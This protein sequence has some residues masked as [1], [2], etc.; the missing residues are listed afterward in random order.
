MSYWDGTRWI[1]DKTAPT[2]PRPS[3]AANWAATAVM[4]IG[5][6]AVIAPLQF[7]AASSHHATTSGCAVNPS[8]TDV[9]ETYVVSAWGL[10]T[11]TAIN[12]WVTENGVTTGEPIGGTTDGTFTLNR[13]S[14]T[15]GVTTYTFSGP[16]GNNMK[17]YGSCTVSAY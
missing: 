10:S 15:A 3:R 2:A 14:Q 5:L 17:I 6:A 9:G 4:V 11:R 7:I 8:T 12:L 16:T 13:S 1:A